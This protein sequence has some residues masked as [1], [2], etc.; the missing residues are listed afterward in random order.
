MGKGVC[1]EL[2]LWRPCSGELTFV[3]GGCPG[4]VLA[5]RGGGGGV[6]E[7]PRTLPAE[8]LVLVKSVMALCARWLRFDKSPLTG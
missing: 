1:D 5:R 3:G 4:P 7:G 2:R 6:T 8:L